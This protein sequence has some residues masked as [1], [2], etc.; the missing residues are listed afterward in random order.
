MDKCPVHNDARCF[1]DPRPGF[2][3]NQEPI[4]FLSK[5][6]KKLVESMEFGS[7]TALEA[8]MFCGTTSLHSRLAEIRRAGYEIKDEWVRTGTGKRVKKYWIEK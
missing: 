1:C 8:M 5:Q 6:N 7:L 3:K 4:F 2:F